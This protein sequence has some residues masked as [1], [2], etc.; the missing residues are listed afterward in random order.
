MATARSRGAMPDM[1][2]L[3]LLGL[4]FLGLRIAAAVIDAVRSAARGRTVIIVTHDQELA[5]ASDR[6]KSLGLEDGVQEKSSA[7]SVTGG[8]R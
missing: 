3:I 1:T 2:L 6:V 8:T 5:R 4:G 7:L